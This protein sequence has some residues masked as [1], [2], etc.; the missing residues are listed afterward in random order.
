ML[1]R[2]LAEQVLGWKAAPGRFR[3][4]NRRWV[5]SWR[6][7]PDRDLNDAFR[8]LEAAKTEEYAMGA[9]KGGKFWCRVEIAGVIGEARDTSQPKAITCAV[10]KA[11][12][13]QAGKK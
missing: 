10:A 13:I 11:L 6:F 3:T 5:P 1:C 4:G 7:Q 9:N 12:G 8:L 2:R